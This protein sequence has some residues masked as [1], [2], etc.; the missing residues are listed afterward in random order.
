M[1]IPHSLTHMMMGSDWNCDVQGCMLDHYGHVRIDEKGAMIDEV[2]IM[3]KMRRKCFQ[4]TLRLGRFDLMIRR[5]D[6]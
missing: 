2:H 4:M 6:R 5:R 3:P 1:A